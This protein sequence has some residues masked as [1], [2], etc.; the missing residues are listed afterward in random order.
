MSLLRPLDESLNVV[1]NGFSE[2][3][4]V[5][6]S[7]RKGDVNRRRRDV[8][9]VLVGAALGTGLVGDG[10]GGQDGQR[11]ARNEYAQHAPR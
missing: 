3:G 5:V 2:R 9:G 6:E 10:G 11:E 1:L 8:A 4:F 7:F